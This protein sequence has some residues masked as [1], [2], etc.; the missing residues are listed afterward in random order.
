MKKELLK[1]GLVVGLSTSLFGFTYEL[2][3]GWQQL[4][5]VENIDNLSE[6]FKDSCIDYIW[7]YENKGIDDPEWKLHVVNETKYDSST[8][9]GNPLT[10]LKKGQG[11]WVKANAD[12]TI[13]VGTASNCDSDMPAPPD[14]DKPECISCDTNTTV[15]HNGVTYGTVI[16]P[17]TGKTWLDRNLGASRVCT[18]IDDS[19]CFGDYYQ[20]G[21]EADGHEK[22]DSPTTS[23]K[24]SDIV[25]VG[26]SF[27]KEDG[28]WITVDTDGSLRTA[29]WSKTD[30]TSICP[31]GFRVPTIDEITTET[32]DQGLTNLETLYGSFLKLP[33]GN[34]RNTTGAMSSRGTNDILAILWSTTNS[35]TDY[36][37]MSFEYTSLSS[38]GTR[39]VENYITYGFNI[40]CIKD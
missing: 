13:N 7:H 2:K 20:W 6:A 39:A 36:K 23:T 26:G 9:C 38:P 22:L 28:D 8:Y 34:Y 10:E 5:A 31:I 4:G 25:N 29:N 18:S 30:G 37:F 15:T 21:R 12:C 40:R 1:M 16:S 32:V 35:I 19:E 11:F 33:D 17:Y 27:I 3:D 24:A 14:L